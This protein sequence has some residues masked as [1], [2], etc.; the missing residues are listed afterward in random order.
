MS[1]LRRDFRKL[2][3]PGLLIA[4]AAL[5]V[6]LGLCDLAIWLATRLHSA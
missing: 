6:L 5:L 1:A 4:L 2:T 3:E